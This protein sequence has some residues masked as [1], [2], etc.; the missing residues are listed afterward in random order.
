MEARGDTDRQIVRYAW[1]KGRKRIER[2]VLDLLSN[3]KFVYPMVT[4][5]E[6]LGHVITLCGQILVS[7]TDD[8]PPFPRRVSTQTCPCVRVY[9][10]HAHVPVIRGTV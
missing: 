7:R 8:H 2:A 6:P 3:L 10:H 4:F 9:R 5:G 1:R